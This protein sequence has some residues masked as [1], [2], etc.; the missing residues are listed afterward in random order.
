MLANISDFNP[1][2]DSVPEEQLEEIDRYMLHRLQALIDDVHENYEQFEYYPIYHRI[3]NFIADVL[4][5]FY[6]DFANDILYIASVNNHY[7]SSIYNVYY[8][9]FVIIDI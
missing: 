9:I 1:E 7:S 6:L 2:T 8:H 5:S 4:S 3:H